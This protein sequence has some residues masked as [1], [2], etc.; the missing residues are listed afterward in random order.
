MRNMEK[1]AFLFT[2][3]LGMVQSS[4]LD[5][6]VPCSYSDQKENTA[7]MRISP[8]TQLS[9][10]YENYIQLMLY[11]TCI[12]FCKSAGPPIGIIIPGTWRPTF[13]QFGVGKLAPLDAC[14]GL[15]AEN[16]GSP[17]PDF[18]AAAM[19]RD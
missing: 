4:L 6:S 5:V 19:R 12:S 8:D 16:F 9:N 10:S 15:L 14:W 18:A 17:P 3:V 11:L 13:G 2:W 1:V 7:T